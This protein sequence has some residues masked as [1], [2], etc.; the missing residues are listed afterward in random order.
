M[1]K[2]FIIQ[3]TTGAVLTSTGSDYLK[4]NPASIEQF[5]R[6]FAAEDVGANAGQTQHAAGCLLI[7][8]ENGYIVEA[9]HAFYK[10]DGVWR[11]EATNLQSANNPYSLTG[12]SR[13]DDYKKLYI[14]DFA[15]HADGRIAAT[16]HVVVQM[17]IG[18]EAAA[19]EATLLWNA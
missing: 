7:S 9:S 6:V 2:F 16:D 10:K 5:A 1:Y 15:A 19:K 4:G 11:K 14:R 13:S 8:I 12:L 3:N 18:T 17:K